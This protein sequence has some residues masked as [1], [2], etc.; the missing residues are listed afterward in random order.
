M[1]FFLIF[2]E[3]CAKTRCLFSSSTLNIAFGSGSMTVAMT[4][5]ASSLAINSN[6]ASNITHSKVAPV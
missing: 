4:S 1:K 2:P 3:M 5:I 6:R